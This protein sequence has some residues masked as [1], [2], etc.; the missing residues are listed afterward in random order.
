M[1]QDELDLDK[2]FLL[3]VAI[4][5]ATRSKVVKGLMKAARASLLKV[6]ILLCF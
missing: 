6:R 3:I 2:P 1:T 4:A 5:A